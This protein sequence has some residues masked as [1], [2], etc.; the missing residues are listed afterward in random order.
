MR[1]TGQWTVSDDCTIAGIG[2]HAHMLAR[3]L[4]IAADIPGRGHVLLAKVPRWDYDWQQPYFFKDPFF[5]PKG[6]VLTA[7]GIFDNSADNP[8]NPFNPPQPV[9]LGESTTDEMLLPML[10]LTAEKQIDAHGHSFTRFGASL[11]RS[12]FLRDLYKDRL[13]F[14]VQPDGAVLR[15]GYTTGDGVFHRFKKPIDPAVPASEYK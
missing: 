6:T 5:L 1:V 7:T 14:E 13:S 8:R 11:E 10:L 15:V 9:F 12:N 2:P 4:E 3:S